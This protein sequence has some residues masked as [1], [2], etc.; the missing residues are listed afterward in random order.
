[1]KTTVSRVVVSVSVAAALGL[2]AACGGG[3][4]A[5][6]DGGGSSTSQA[7]PKPKS[8]PKGSVE[9]EG[10]EGGSGSAAA[11]ELRAS[12]VAKGD[13]EGYSVGRRERSKLAAVSDGA[14]ANPTAC[15]PLSDMLAAATPP[16]ATAHA[17]RTVTQE[18]RRAEGGATDVE[19]FA[20]DS[21][22]GARDALRDLRSAVKSKKCAAFRAGGMRYTG[23]APRSAPD[24]GEEAVAYK[25][26]SH[27]ESYVRRHSVV[28]VRDGS[29]LV[30]FAA[31]NFYDPQGVAAGEESRA[32]GGGDV[33]GSAGADEEPVVPSTVVDAQLRRVG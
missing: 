15:R 17:G 7:K 31:K 20:Y 3:D 16:K 12:L 2:T 27:E 19:L 5:G 22:D 13:V 4:G 1:M 10:G 28:V 8:D 24:G 21:A 25:I 9:G 18:S 11:K 30:S 26:G 33:P 14:P 32:A 6:R 29:T 23:V